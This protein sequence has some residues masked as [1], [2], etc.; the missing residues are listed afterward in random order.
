M[1]TQATPIEPPILWVRALAPR[2]AAPQVDDEKDQSADRERRRRAAGEGIEADRKREVPGVPPRPGSPRARLP[3]GADFFFTHN[4]TS[5]LGAGAPVGRTR[6]GLASASAAIVLAVQA[7]RR[8]FERR[9]RAAAP[10]TDPFQQRRVGTGRCHLHERAQVRFGGY[11]HQELR[12]W[13]RRDAE[14]P[15]QRLLLPGPRPVRQ[16]RPDGAIV[17]YGQALRLD[18]TDTDY[19]NSRAAAYEAKKDFDKAMADYN[20]AIRVNPNSV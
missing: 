11:G 7:H 4:H 14:E 3:S 15:R 18:P 8:V 1:R 20:Q 2:P 9:K 19:L 16:Q 5:E 12:C 6:R 13:D 17:D 10:G